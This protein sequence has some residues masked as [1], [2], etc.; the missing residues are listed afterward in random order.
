M[1]L[2]PIFLPILAGLVVGLYKPMK[3]KKIRNPFVAGITILNTAMLLYFFLNGVDRLEL[4]E[5]VRGIPILLKIDEAGMLF[6]GLVSVMWVCVGFFAFEYVKH[7]KREERFFMFFL[8]TLGVLM[9]VGMSGNLVTL[10]AFY[11]C[12]TI[13]TVPLVLHSVSKQAVAAGLKYLFYSVFG[14]SFGL[15]GIFFLNHYTET[16]EFTARGT[17]DLSK[18]AGHETGLL[19]IIFL[20]ILGFGTKAGMFPLQG[21]LPTAHPV[22]PAPASAVL[23][24]IITKAG[25]L[26]IIR[27]VFYLVG[28]DFIRGTWV[29]YAWMILALVTVFM[30]SMLAYKEQILKKRLAYSTVSQVSYILFGLSLLNVD[31]FIGGSMHIVFHSLIKDVL[32]LC[33][34]AIIYKTHI[35]EVSELRGIGKKMPITMWCF[36]FV[37]LALVGIPPTSG[38]V[39]KWYLAIGALKLDNAL[40]Y[41]GPVVLLVSAL[42]TAGYLIT[43][44]LKGFFPGDDFD[45]QKEKKQEASLL[46]T[47][48]IIVLTIGAVVFGMFPTQLIEFV[49]SIAEKL[50]NG[51]IL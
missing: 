45:Y 32:F 6:T 36:A 38:F 35:T 27:V 16:L 30:G 15:L 44:V 5:I 34:G 3:D 11:E 2:I 28:P 9:G 31:G 10:Y 1:L 37:S 50:F 26:A 13:V 19:I 18:V 33:A 8:I 20:M 7:E 47:V 46:M 41:I 17:L 25:V 39:S 22:A 42:L 23:S 4:M 14:A 49:T 29:Q 24:G 48:P 51:G 12:M 43:I 21:W 40:A